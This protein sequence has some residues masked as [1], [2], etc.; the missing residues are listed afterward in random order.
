MHHSHVRDIF[1]IAHLLGRN[2]HIANCNMEDLFV[3]VS[4]PPA[5]D[6]SLFLKW[7]QGIPL[8]ATNDKNNAMLAKNIF[9]FR[10]P[11][12]PYF[13]DDLLLLDR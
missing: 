11:V 12:D 7:L 1:F 8:A 2:Y 4:S 13:G 9:Q 3:C 6:E 5:F 10:H